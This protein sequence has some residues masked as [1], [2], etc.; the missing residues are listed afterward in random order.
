[1]EV[2]KNQDCFLS[3]PFFSFNQIPG[4]YFFIQIQSKAGFV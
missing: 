4:G 3:P 2:I 1:M